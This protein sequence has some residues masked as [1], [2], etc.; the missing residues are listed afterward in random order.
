MSIFDKFKKIF[1]SGSDDAFGEG[2]T[3]DLGT[4]KQQTIGVEDQNI[5]RNIENE[6]QIKIDKAFKEKLLEVLMKDY[7]QERLIQFGQ[8]IKDKKSSVNDIMSDLDKL[9]NV[10]VN[11]MDESIIDDY[12]QNNPDVFKMSITKVIIKNFRDYGEKLAKLNTSNNKDGSKEEYNFQKE[13]MNNFVRYI[14]NPTTDLYNLCEYLDL[15]YKEYINNRGRIITYFNNESF[16]LQEMLK[17]AFY[18]ILYYRRFQQKAF[19]DI[20]AQDKQDFLNRINSFVEKYNK[21]GTLQLLFYY[22]VSQNKYDST[23]KSKRGDII[24]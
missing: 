7:V 12:F 3:G 24:G 2:I 15:L 9:V 1:S 8:V 5:G 16:D 21:D 13:Q 22:A 20:T 23:P 6:Q 14:S 18:I 19:F 11:S 17:D 10:I 4:L